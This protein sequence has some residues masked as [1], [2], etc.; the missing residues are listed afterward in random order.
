MKKFLLNFALPLFSGKLGQ[1][2]R[3]GVLRNSFFQRSAALSVL[4][5]VLLS[6]SAFASH[7]KGGY[8]TYSYLGEG[9]YEFIITG[10][11]EKDAVGTIFPRY[12]GPS[13]RHG[14]PLT[15][16]KTLLKDGETVEHVQRQ[17]VSWSSPGVYMAYWTTCCRT[18]GSNFDNNAMGLFAVVNYNPDVPSSSPQFNGNRGFDFNSKQ[19]INFT[20]NIE[21]PEAHEQEFSL[22]IPYDLPADAYQE[23]FETGFQLRK[24]GAIVWENPI[25]GSWLVSIKVH[26]KIDGLFTG[27]YILRDF[28]IN[29][30]A[31]KKPDQGNPANKKGGNANARSNAI[32]GDF[33]P[34]ATTGIRVYPHPVKGSSQL[35]V[36]L[37]EADWIRV[38]VIDLSGKLVKKLY[39]GN[40]EAK[41][42]LSLQIDSKEFGSGK[43]YIGRITTS[44]GVETFKIAIQ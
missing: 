8:F 29:V 38:E 6:S 28:V 39:A 42:I 9:R 32:V 23:M 25:E 30:S 43:L 20:V 44:K 3:E 1:A 18:V 12:Q 35:K 14:F 19:R 26:E 41:E 10:Y 40:I 27:A 33:T 11:W 17:E 24:N 13:K 15:V 37:E 31:Q 5:L 22:E 16:S 36:A 34:E 21:D 4:L 2:F 7:F